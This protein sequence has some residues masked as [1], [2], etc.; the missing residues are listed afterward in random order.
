MKSALLAAF[1]VVLCFSCA[2]PG[3]RGPAYARPDWRPDGRLRI[4]VIDSALRPPNANVVLYQATDTLPSHTVASFI[5]AEGDAGE[6]AWVVSMMLDYAR[7][8]GANGVALL[9]ADRP[10]ETLALAHPI[11]Q[12]PGR[13]IF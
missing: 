12:S 8:I 1:V 4:A 5:S 6:E 9:G 10:N 7:H 13:R 11:W 2:E 3:V